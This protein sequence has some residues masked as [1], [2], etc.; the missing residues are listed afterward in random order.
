MMKRKIVH[1]HEELCNGCQLCVQAC[2]EA[3]IQMVDG[4]AKLLSDKYCDGLGDC[5]PAC[6]TGAIEIIERDAVAYDEEAVNVLLKS[7]GR[8]PL[9]SAAT[10]VVTHEEKAPAAA[11]MGFGG[12]CP[13]SQA[14]K[15]AEQANA[16]TS[17]KNDDTNGVRP[18]QLRQW[19]IQINLIN[20]AAD[21]LENADILIAADCTAFAYGDFHKDFMK[22]KVTMIGCPKLDDNQFYAQKL[23]NIFTNANIRSVTVARMEVPC[24]GGIVASAQHALAACGKQIPYSE[25]IIGV[26]GERR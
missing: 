23:T 21:Y 5:L 9:Q 16:A 25:H 8:A 14:R 11:P 4:K 6:P 10:Q 26:G 12:G 22:G 17:T 3:A 1:I 7:L 13:G 24:C 19:P 2:H 20:P 15:L 18:S